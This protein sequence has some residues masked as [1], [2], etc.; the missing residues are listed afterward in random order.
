MVV[1]LM[2]LILGLFLAGLVVVFGGEAC[3][4]FGWFLSW[5]SWVVCGQ[6]NVGGRSCFCVSSDD[7]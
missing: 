2:V 1:F 5:C 3:G 4:G 6:W 7:A